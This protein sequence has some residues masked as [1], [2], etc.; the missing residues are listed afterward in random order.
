M[1][2]G[3]GTI[4][5][6]PGEVVPTG[7]IYLVV[8]KGHRDMHEVSLSA[9]EKFPACRECGNRVRFELLL[10]LPPQGGSGDA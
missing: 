8:H 6:K 9:D 10:P 5:F 4:L 2:F 1:A 7:G 3:S